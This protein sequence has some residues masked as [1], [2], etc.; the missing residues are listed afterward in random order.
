MKNRQPLSAMYV[1]GGQALSKDWENI[2]TDELNVK[3]LQFKEDLS[4]FTAYIFK[5]Q[6]KRWDR[7]TE[8]I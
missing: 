8:S 3:S 4:D 1:S 6:L 7:S 5:P 2:I